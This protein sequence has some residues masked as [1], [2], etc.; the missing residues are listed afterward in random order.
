MELIFELKDKNGKSVNLGD[1][2]KFLDIA[3]DSGSAIDLFGVESH[4]DSW[5]DVYYV[6]EVFGVVE[7][8]HDLLMIVVKTKGGRKYTFAEHARYERNCQL[9]EYLKKDDIEIAKEDFGLN[10]VTAE[11]ISDS[12]LKQD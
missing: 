3:N 12:I 6:H 8:D 9:M 1:T 10:N 7:F 5:I 2:V 11:S 4:L